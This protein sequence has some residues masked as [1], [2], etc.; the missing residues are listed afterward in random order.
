MPRDS[1]D[2]QL[3]VNKARPGWVHTTFKVGQ[4]HLNNHGVRALG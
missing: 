3:V 4:A 2:G 1:S